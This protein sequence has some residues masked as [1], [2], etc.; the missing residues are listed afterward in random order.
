MVESVLECS[1]ESVNGGICE[2]NHFQAITRV[3]K[4]IYVLQQQWLGFPSYLVYIFV[5][6]ALLECV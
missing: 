2:S 4:L 1:A 3:S 6:S 5:H